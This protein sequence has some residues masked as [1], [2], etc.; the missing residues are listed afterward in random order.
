M[1]PAGSRSG[2]WI[3]LRYIFR[4]IVQLSVGQSLAVVQHGRVEW[5]SWF[6]KQTTWGN[7]KVRWHHPV[8]FNNLHLSCMNLHVGV[9]LP[10]EMCAV[11]MICRIHNS[12]K[13]SDVGVLADGKWPQIYREANLDEFSSFY[14]YKYIGLCW[15]VLIC[16]FWSVTPIDHN[17]PLA[18][19]TCNSCMGHFR[20]ACIE[21]K[22]STLVNKCTYTRIRVCTCIGKGYNLKNIP[23]CIQ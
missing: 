18:T 7:Q 1:G 15:Y 17:K 8:I 23:K 12:F 3:E 5:D 11:L 2:A 16:A 20:G 6:N 10:S 22:L 19:S 21:L 9:N 13:I 14:M 4:M